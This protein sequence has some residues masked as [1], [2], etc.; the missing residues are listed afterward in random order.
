MTPFTLYL[1]DEPSGAGAVH[2]G[3]CVPTATATTEGRR[4]TAG[5]GAPGFGSMP[6]HCGSPGMGGWL[7]SWLALVPTYCLLWSTAKAMEPPLHLLVAPSD[8][9]TNP[10][11]RVAAQTDASTLMSTVEQAQHQLRAALAQGSRDVVIEL[12]PGNHRVAEGGLVITA[13]D[14]PFE[15]RHTVVWRGS[16]GSALSGH[17]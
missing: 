10:S 5:L 15:D 6:A 12:L 7:I 14:S 4:R 16:A 13:E 8:D 9:G 1:Q 17:G 3:A 11:G 2:G